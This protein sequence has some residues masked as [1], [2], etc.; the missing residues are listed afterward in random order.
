MFSK[1]KVV[2]KCQTAYVLQ[3]PRNIYGDVER[4]PEETNPNWTNWCWKMRSQ[5]QIPSIA[6]E[7][8]E[9][10]SSSGKGDR[11]LSSF[12]FSQVIEMGRKQGGPTGFEVV[13]LPKSRNRK[14][15][16]NLYRMNTI[17]IHATH[18]EDL[19]SLLS[20]CQ[21]ESIVMGQRQSS[22]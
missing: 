5:L 3:D 19:L 7:A 9:L 6:G 22:V 12:P 11:G 21:P 20:C 13:K 10:I 14:S 8:I 17:S 18:A 2:A 15:L 4:S 1:I 16:R